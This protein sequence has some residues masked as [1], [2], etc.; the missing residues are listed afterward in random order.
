[1]LW[2]VVLLKAVSIGEFITDKWKQPFAKDLGD[3]KLRVHVSFEY[4]DLRQPLLGDSGPHVHFDRMFR[5]VFKLWLLTL[6]MKAKLAVVFK[7]NGTLVREYHI[8]K[9]FIFLHAV[10]NTEVKET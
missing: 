6:A 8:I 7:E 4:C 10:I 5:F 1:M 2:I 3:I 9:L